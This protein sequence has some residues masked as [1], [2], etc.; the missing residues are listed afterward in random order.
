[1]GTIGTSCIT[2]SYSIFMVMLSLEDPICWQ[3]DVDIQHGYLSQFRKELL[4]SDSCALQ[5]PSCF[6]LSSPGLPS[7]CFTDGLHMHDKSN[8]FWA[9]CVHAAAICPQLLG[10]RQPGSALAPAG[11][12]AIWK[13]L[14][15]RQ[16]LFPPSPFSYPSTPSLSTSF[17]LATHCGC[18]GGVSPSFTEH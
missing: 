17:Q 7:I 12:L 14:T 11:L 16:A 3:S 8:V 2:A 10:V 6:H 18:F 1:M 13:S 4:Y 5:G 15:H 9:Y